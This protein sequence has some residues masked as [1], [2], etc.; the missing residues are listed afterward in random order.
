ML[1]RKCVVISA[2]GTA[3]E[4]NAILSIIYEQLRKSNHKKM[5]RIYFS[6][7]LHSAPVICHFLYRRCPLQL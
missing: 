6:Y 1:F 5:K 4:S 3:P 2:A 7:A